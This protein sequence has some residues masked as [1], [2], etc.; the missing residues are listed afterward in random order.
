[1]LAAPKLKTIDRCDGSE[2]IKTNFILELS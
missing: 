1:M 2:S